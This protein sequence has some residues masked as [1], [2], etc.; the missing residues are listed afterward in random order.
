MKKSVFTFI[1]S[2]LAL[3]SSQGAIIISQYY[4]GASNNKW[5]ELFNTDTVNAVDFATLGLKVGIWTN[6]GTEG[7]KTNVAPGST[8][9][10]SGTIAPGGYYLL[11]NTSAV[12]PSY[13]IADASNNSVNAFNG[14]DSLAL[15]TGV[16][17]ASANIVD[18]I[19]FTTAG[20]EGADK[21]FVRANNAAPGWN[22]TAGSRATDFSTVWTSVTN[23]TV[24]NAATGTP[25]RL[26]SSVPEPSTLVTLMGGVGLLMGFR[27][28]RGSYG[29]TQRNPALA[30]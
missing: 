16:T 23:A 18:A 19:G 29:N 14:D 22:L 12:L 30:R 25:E 27:R 20:N 5:I 13:A 8:F 3:I 11:K 4:E 24:D 21:S 6:A 28:L 10:L 26:V 15:W 7:Y 17:F 1:F 9:T 2:S